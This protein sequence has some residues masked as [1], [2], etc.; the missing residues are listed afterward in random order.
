LKKA[1]EKARKFE[2]KGFKSGVPPL[3]PG[4]KIG[5]LESVVIGRKK[6]ERDGVSENFSGSEKGTKKG[7]SA[8]ARRKKQVGLGGNRKGDSSSSS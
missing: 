4:E 7:G 6:A 3:I 1:K 8:K 5:E 2:K